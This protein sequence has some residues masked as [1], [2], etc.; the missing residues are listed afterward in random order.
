MS[1]T[2]K[3]MVCA[4]LGFFALACNAE[5]RPEQTESEFGF[6]RIASAEE[7]AG[8]DIDVRFDGLGLPPGRGSATEGA[9]TYDAK[10]AACHG[11]ELEGNPNL[12]VRPLVSDFR[13]SVNNLPY[14]PPL[15]AYIRRSMPLTAPGS[16]SDNEVYGLVAFLLSRAGID[17]A[18]D[19]ILD[20]A[21]LAGVRMPNRKNFFSDDDS[22]VALPQPVHPR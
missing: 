12:G 18:P 2:P 9:A 13:H 5:K 1:T 16:L 11:S 15:F 4:A 3:A 14:A 21:A 22:G 20:A 19:L 17:T 10:C 8:A 6:G 7:I